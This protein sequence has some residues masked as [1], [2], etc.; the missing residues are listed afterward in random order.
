M[1]P[2]RFSIHSG[3]HRKGIGYNL[4]RY[5]QEKDKHAAKV[6]GKKFNLAGHVSPPPSESA[7]DDVH[8]VR[9]KGISC[10]SRN[11]GLCRA[12]RRLELAYRRS[13]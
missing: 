13:V 4:V 1:G 5:R 10:L 9:C 12:V 7:D 3:R 6:V 11:V 8:T 2:V